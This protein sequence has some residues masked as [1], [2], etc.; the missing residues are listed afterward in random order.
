VRDALSAA[1]ATTRFAYDL[2]E[3]GG[4]VA[5][6]SA[7]IQ[8]VSFDAPAGPATILVGG[9]MPRTLTRYDLGVVTLTYAGPS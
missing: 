3:L 5:S 2:D 4:V 1:F 7:D 6:A 8:Q 9:A